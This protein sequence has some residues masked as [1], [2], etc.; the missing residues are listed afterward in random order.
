[1]RL[2]PLLLSFAVACAAAQPAP[3]AAPQPSPSAPVAGLQPPVAPKK[4]RVRDV[5]GEKF[6]DDYFWLR[7]KGTPEVEGYLRSELAYAE[8]FMK[9]TAALQQKLYDEMLSRIQQTDVNVPY[10]WRGFYY[11]SR[12]EEGR[13]Y[14]IHCRKKGSLE[15]AEEI[16]LDVNK[17]GEGKKF[18]SVPAQEVSPSGE[19]LAYL[20]DD[21]GFRQFTLHVKDLRSGVD[22][23]ETMVRVTGIA[24]FNDN[25]SLFYTVEDATTKRSFQLF[26]HTLGAAKDDLVYEEKDE[27]FEVSVGATRDREV[28]FVVSSSQNES[29]VRFLSANRPLDPLQLIAAREKDHEY[30]VDH[31][32]G[33]FYIRTNSGG[34]NFRLV[35]APAK[36]PSRKNWKELVAHRDAVMLE[37][38]DL[39]KDFYVLSER[40][41]GFP[42]LRIVEFKNGSS[43][44]ISFPEQAYDVEAEDNHEWDLQS[45]RFRYHSPITPPSVFDYEIATRERK[46]LKRTPVLGGYDPSR[47]EVALTA[48]PASDGA[49]VP[50]WTLSL[51]GLKRDGTNP[52]LLYAYGAYGIAEGA[53]FNSNIFSLIDRGLVFATAFVRGGGELGKKWHDQGR[54]LTK[55]N[56]FTDFIAAAEH[57]IAQGITSKE[58]LA[59]EGGSAG[60]L[61]MGAVTNLRPDLF[62]VVLALMPWVDVINDQLDESL[63]L[64]VTEFQEWGNP[65]ILDQYRYMRSY[66]PYDNLEA[67]A[68]P[69]ILVRSSYNDSQVMYWG[70]AKYVARLRA[71]KTDH[72]PLI[73]AIS[74]DPAGHGGKSGRYDRLRDSAFNMAFVLT[75]LGVE[76]L[77]ASQAPKTVK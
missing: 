46:L 2:Q 51:K 4:P 43:H 68:Y 17:L 52:A 23:P 9:P 47:Y 59:V 15:G 70:P 71:L 39:F 57:L 72:N 29:E 16:I 69:T 66:S 74:M 18:M 5:N 62:K 32:E 44:R 25:K 19:L 26:R 10:R 27:Q 21:T 49:K 31:R 73:F 75:Q 37:N 13:Q 65:K 63:P 38:V 30:Y 67:K 14:P 11:Y 40:E 58:R 12:T 6:V 1:M 34:R 8:A 60:G 50:I 45:L 22:L 28:V 20:T 7:E 35:T 54:L 77:E 41:S 42:Q 55:R 24:W 36:D 61:L 64:T 56:T 53:Y 33:V 76:K 3:T 48:A